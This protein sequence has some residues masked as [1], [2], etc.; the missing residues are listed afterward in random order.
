MLGS[1][2]L[3][4]CNNKNG[5]FAVKL[6]YKKVY[7]VHFFGAGH[8]PQSTYLQAFYDDPFISI[9]CELKT[10]SKTDFLSH[11]FLFLSP[12]C[13]YY[14]KKRIFAVQ[15]EGTPFFHLKSNFV[16]VAWKCIKVIQCNE[17]YVSSNEKK[18]EWVPIRPSMHTS[19]HTLKQERMEMKN[20]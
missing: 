13:N 8:I 2:R 6:I 15:K 14:V 3:N 20:T 16:L 17:F 1:V 7:Y 18:H 5:I 19:T 10:N 12:T 4:I 11:S 9:H